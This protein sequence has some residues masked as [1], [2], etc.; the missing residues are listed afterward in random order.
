MHAYNV[1]PLNSRRNNLLHISK[2]KRGTKVHRLVTSLNEKSLVS[3]HEGFVTLANRP[4]TPSPLVQFKVIWVCAGDCFWKAL[5]KKP[6]FKD[7]LKWMNKFAVL[8]NAL[9]VLIKWGAE[10]NSALETAQVHNQKYIKDNSEW[11]LLSQKWAHWL[12]RRQKMTCSLLS[13]V[14][15]KKLFN[16]HGGF[17]SWFD[18]VSHY[19]A[20]MKDVR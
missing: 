19:P 2:R 1:G 16:N 6:L 13:G 7:I 11:E 18:T 15:K 9:C 12:G 8:K 20:S 4:T 5:R 14:S 3:L 17:W 10:L